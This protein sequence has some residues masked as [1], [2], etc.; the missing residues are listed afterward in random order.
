MEVRSVFINWISIIQTYFQLTY[1]SCH[2]MPD[3]DGFIYNIGTSFITGTCELKFV[4][5]TKRNSKRSFNV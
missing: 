4:N 2:P 5:E 1:S 3:D